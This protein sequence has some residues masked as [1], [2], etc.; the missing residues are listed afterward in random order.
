MARRAKGF[1][2]DLLVIF[3]LVAI[4]YGIY[5][6]FF[7]SNEEEQPEINS[8]IEQKIENE[9]PN[10][11]T[12]IE[13]KIEKNEEA[14]T[15][16]ISNN[17]P[18]TI[19]KENITSVTIENSKPQTPI[20]GNSI[21]PATVIEQPK[22]TTPPVIVKEPI[23]E[24]QKEAQIKVEQTVV[25][26]NTLEAD[27]K[28]KVEQFFETI[29]KQILLNLDTTLDKSKITKGE[30]TNFKVTV[31]K[32]GGYEQITYLSGNKEYYELVKPAIRKAF[33][34]QMD[35]ALKNSFPRYFRMKIEF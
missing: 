5:S 4:I 13:Q 33:P 23:K 12:N 3:V 6:Y 24:M 1:L 26:T 22:E 14:K 31:L 20:I 30:F 34:V 18:A 28:I 21:P 17:E 7:A 25:Q 10:K 15:E 9:T 27:E 32:D 2:E 29:R 35:P 16:S 11:L 19:Q 8:T